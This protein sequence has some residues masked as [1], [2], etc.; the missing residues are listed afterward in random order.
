MGSATQR[1]Q[2]PERSIRSMPAAPLPASNTRALMDLLW[3]D[4][5]IALAVVDCRRRIRDANAAAQPLLA[6]YHLAPGEELAGLTE[7]VCL[8][9]G[10]TPCPEEA[11]P[12]RRA[13][14]GEIVR[15][16]TLIV[17]FAG[18]REPR[19]LTLSALPVALDDGSSGALLLWH[20]VTESWH[21]VERTRDELTECTAQLE[22][23]APDL[24]AANAELEAFSYGVSHDLRAPLRAIS[25]FTR[26]VQEDHADQLPSEALRY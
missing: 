17:L 20:D 7:K 23:R 12:L 13:L 21:S 3:A 11:R 1:A 26:I 16:E 24:A 18:V 19:R 5:D 10:R 15:R 14:N 9:D 6:R 25:G 8:A 22:R 2:E 4:A